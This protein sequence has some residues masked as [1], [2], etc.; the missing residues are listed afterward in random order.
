MN[1]ES[2]FICL[3]FSALLFLALVFGLALHLRRL[4]HTLERSL[5]VPGRRLHSRPCVVVSLTLPKLPDSLL[6]LQRHIGLVLASLSENRAHFHNP[7][8]F[9]V[10]LRLICDFE[11]LEVV[12]VLFENLCG[13]VFGIVERIRRKRRARG[14]L[15]EEREPR[16][17]QFFENR[18][19]R[20][21]WV[22]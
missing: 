17:A 11:L 10:E 12:L 8:S 1:R 7:L 2:A 3:F 9:F 13:P 21:R 4:L 20:E 14:K 15:L 16:T 22:G 6:D 5:D 18:G 19:R